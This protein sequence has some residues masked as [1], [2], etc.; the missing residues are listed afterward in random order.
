MNTT[1][2][3]LCPGLVGL[4]ACLSTSAVSS[5]DAA[6]RKLEAEAGFTLLE[7]LVVIAVIASLASLVLPALGSAKRQVRT[8]QCKSNLHQLGIALHLYAQDDNCYPLA[9]SDG[10]FGAWEPAL[11]EFVPDSGFYCPLQQTPSTQFINI[12]QLT[13]AP[14]SPH[15]GYNALG[16]VWK[17]SPPY[18]PGLGGDL[19]LAT[20]S[21]EPTSANRV[22]TPAQMITI[23]DSV[24]FIDAILG[25]QPQTNIPNQIYIVFPYIVEPLGYLGVANWHD[26]GANMLFGDAH[27]Q[28]C[29]QSF[30]IA[31]TDQSRRLWN[32]DNQ[33]HPEWW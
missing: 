25:T 14:I 1:G 6:P 29:Q 30:W 3:E 10:V 26:G 32:S 17:G 18:N 5:K 12:F 7:L 2:F 23:G 15:Y 19:N 16:A 33:P 8:A 31:A 13:E 9:T 28:F 24:T 11:R 4:T 22:I 21:R 27:V 20:G